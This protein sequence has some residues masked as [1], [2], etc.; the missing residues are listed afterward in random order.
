MPRRITAN[1]KSL[2]GRVYTLH[3]C[4]PLSSLESIF[5][6]SPAAQREAYGLSTL[7]VAALK[8]KQKASLPPR[9]PSAKKSTAA[10]LEEFAHRSIHTV[11]SR[12]SNTPHRLPGPVKIC[13]EEK[14]LI[15]VYPMSKAVLPDISVIPVFWYGYCLYVSGLLPERKYVLRRST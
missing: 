7:T 3:I 8:E 5:P 6:R 1:K 13:T 15:N 12:V 10:S 2:W 9:P 4:L 11:Y 14:P